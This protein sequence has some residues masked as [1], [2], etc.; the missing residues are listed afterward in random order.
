MPK[1]LLA[2][3]WLVLS[4]A[5]WAQEPLDTVIEV[6]HPELR[7][8]IFKGG[9]E[10]VSA[11]EQDKIAEQ[12]RKLIP[13][14]GANGAADA[15]PELVREAYQNKGYFNVEVEGRTVPAGAYPSD[16][17]WDLI[18]SVREGQQ[19]R[20]ASIGWRNVREFPEQQLR[21]LMPI[22]DGDFFDRSKIARG[23]DAVQK[24]Y[25]TGGFINF[26]SVPETKLDEA[27]TRIYLIINVDEG[28]LFRWG[29]LRITGLDETHTQALLRAWDDMHGK[30][31]LS[32][33]LSDF[34]AKFVLPV[35]TGT[36]LHPSTGRWLD[37]KTGTVDVIIS[38]PAVR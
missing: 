7:N 11:Q 5:V 17:V 3:A 21:D 14:V 6:R 15:A 25:D 30:P 8:I 31:S 38:F 22:G 29:D 34:F 18:L 12:I 27:N 16:L 20:L 24:L 36:N 32:A 26:T 33:T 23:L 2:L 4:S 1:P 28:K 13:R 35:Q 10:V 19:Y 37:E 9:A